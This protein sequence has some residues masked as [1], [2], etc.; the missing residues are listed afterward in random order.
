MK[1]QAMHNE[2]QQDR[3]T[4]KAHDSTQLTNEE[5]FEFDWQTRF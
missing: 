4:L 5:F 3:E 2:M 1:Q